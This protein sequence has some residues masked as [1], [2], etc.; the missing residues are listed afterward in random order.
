MGICASIIGLFRKKPKRCSML[1]AITSSVCSNCEEVIHIFKQLHKVDN[2]IIN[3]DIT[4]PVFNKYFRK[5]IGYNRTVP[6]IVYM[7]YSSSCNKYEPDFKRIDWCKEYSGL[8]NKTDIMT[9]YRH[10]LLIE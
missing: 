10:Q 6:F 9:F 8:F 3:I 5:R 7:R 4:N 1:I 2:R